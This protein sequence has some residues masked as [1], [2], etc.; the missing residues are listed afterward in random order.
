[1]TGLIASRQKDWNGNL[2]RGCNGRIFTGH[3]CKDHVPPG[4][5]G[6]W[7]EHDYPTDTKEEETSAGLF[8]RMLKQAG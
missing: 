1:M 6:K 7:G 3:Y 8:D 4:L 2:C 5:V